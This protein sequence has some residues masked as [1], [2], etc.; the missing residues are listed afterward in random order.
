MRV[1]ESFAYTAFVALLA[2]LAIWLLLHGYYSTSPYGRGYRLFGSQVAGGV[3]LS[4][5]WSQV[6]P[7]IRISRGGVDGRLSG[8]VRVRAS[9]NAAPEFGIVRRVGVRCLVVGSS[10][11]FVAAVHFT[12]SEQDFLADVRSACRSG[13][14]EPRE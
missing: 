13:R 5:I 2:L 7:R 3:L 6:R 10:Q 9:P 1:R 8:F 11:L 12:G 4:C 14:P